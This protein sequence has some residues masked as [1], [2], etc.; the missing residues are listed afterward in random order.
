MTTMTV[1]L[2]EP[3][4][5]RRLINVP[6]RKREIKS[7]QIGTSPPPSIWVDEPLPHPDYEFR[8][9][10]GDWLAEPKHR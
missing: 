7:R 2:L 9:V 4:G 1:T 5:S 3:D 6:S 8:S 10:I